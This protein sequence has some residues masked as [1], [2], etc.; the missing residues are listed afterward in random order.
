[1]CFSWTSLKNIFLVLKKHNLWCSWYHVLFLIETCY[2][3][4]MLTNIYRDFRAWL[5]I[6]AQGHYKY[7]CRVRPLALKALSQ[8]PLIIRT[9]TFQSSFWCCWFVNLTCKN[10][11]NLQCHL[12]KL[13]ISYPNQDSVSSSFSVCWCKSHMLNISAL[14]CQP[15]M[16][17]AWLGWTDGFVYFCT[18][19]FFFLVCKVAQ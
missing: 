5:K 17:N 6:A 7:G 11:T 8:K 13:I 15:L 19:F 14:V 18:I 3:I 1:M 12:T 2:W 10:K 9:V 4:V 16:H